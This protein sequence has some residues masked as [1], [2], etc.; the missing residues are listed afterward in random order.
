[1]GADAFKVKRGEVYLADPDP[2]RG[3]EQG[4]RRPHLVISVN[5]MNRSA[6]GL[7]IGVPLTTTNWGSK[8]HVRL[9]PPEGGL[10]RVSFAMPEMARSVSSSRLLAKLGY[11]SADTVEAV[12][13]HVGILVGLGRAR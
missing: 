3:H 6:A 10:S 11:A 4:G 9:E 8:L 1:M 7:L 13:K 5:Q 2:V 12:A